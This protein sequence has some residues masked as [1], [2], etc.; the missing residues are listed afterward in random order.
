MWLPCDHDPSSTW[1]S[2]GHNWFACADP[3]EAALQTASKSTRHS[4]FA[5]VTTE[6]DAPSNPAD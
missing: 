1:E 2:A 4:L 5:T 6:T 3:T